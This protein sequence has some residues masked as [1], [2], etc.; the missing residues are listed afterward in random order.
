MAI[1]CL[2]SPSGITSRSL[3]M[4]E[5]YMMASFRKFFRT[6]AFL[7]LALL[8]LSSPLLAAIAPDVTSL[9][10][11]S[12]ALSTPVRLSADSGGVLYVTDPRAGGVVKYSSNGS[13]EMTIPAASGILGVAVAA[14]GNILVSQG[15]VVGVFSPAGVKL[16]EFGTFGKANGIAV[17][18]T[19]AIFVV[20]SL[21]NEVQIFNK[22]YTSAGRF[23]KVGTADGFFRQPTGIT[24]EKLADQ[25]AVTDTRNG[26]VQFFSTTGLFKKSI[27]SFGAG[28]LKFTSP[29][30]VSFEYTPDQSALKRIYIVDSYQS[31]IQV[32]DGA[33]LEFIRYIGGYG[34]ADGK[35]IT[36]SDILFDKSGRLVVANGTGKLSL[37]GVADPATGPYLQL[38]TVP[39]ATNQS[40]L[41]ISG[42][43]TG[44]T[45][46]VNGL[47]AT[48]SGTSWSVALPL[49]PGTNLI[50][51]TATDAAGLTTTRTASVL[52]IA[53][54]PNPVALTVQP[55]PAVVANSSLV[56]K[57]SVT[58]GSSVSVNGVS[59]TVSGTSWSANI[60]LHAGANTLAISAAKA[61][62]DTSTIDLTVTLDTTLPAIVTQLP[63]SGSV[64][65]SPLQTITGSASSAS[66]TTIILTVNGI[67][68]TVSVSD[69][70]FSLPIVLNPGQN[71]ISIAAVDSFGAM[72]QLPT[73]TVS[74]DPQA[75]HLTISTPAAAVSGTS[76]YHLEG[77]A[78]AGSTVT[79]NGS[80]IASVS[81]T[82]WSADV[83][84]VPG[85]NNFEV[86]AV[87]PSGSATS[88]MT[89]VSYSSGIPSLAIVSPIRDSAVASSTYNIS[90]TSSTG[91]VV[92]AL[93]N[94]VPA[95][96]TSS[97]NGAFT[98]VIP[99]MTQGTYT[100]VVSATNTNTG[101]T[102]TT[103]RSVIYDPVPPLLTVSSSV[104]P[105]K[106]SAPGGV[107]VASDKN[108]PVGTVTYSGGVA[109][110]D[111]TNVIYD[112]ATLN[113][114]ALSPAGLTSRS[115][116]FTGAAKP[117][118]ADALKA[119]RVAAR[120]DPTPAFAEML[121]GDVAPM[122]NFESRPDGK[123]SLDDVVVI[124][125]RILGIIP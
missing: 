23:G 81:G 31:T 68:Q 50:V 84:L 95:Q 6:T 3:V 97:S 115:G 113:I 85:V 55:L 90:G 67:T 24:Y 61:G 47:P 14:D 62:M 73:T 103:T 51:V 109:S 74:Y 93:I 96:V 58:A 87:T 78:P 46:S 25:I 1:K 86:T 52:A 34:V 108:G 117:T 49:V 54:S 53:S 123:I 100:V 107:L 43:T 32:I 65:S 5:P 22:D 16:R 99:N 45:V 10:S 121:T 89:S 106:V 19:G 9:S 28:P 125:N 80:V 18:G 110:L 36:P 69:G 39:Q 111:L 98:V 56:V 30:S 48:I 79:I 13:Y 59:A 88:A 119:L 7:M 57:G 63:V 94:S 91:V 35:L 120:I 2:I 42:T 104:L 26:R 60:T 64:F 41:L 92:T 71:A 21:N 83:Q 4:E 27:G 17:T 20:D 75:P 114:Q 40:S 70:V 29:Q 12:V 15:A 112:A 105:I 44:L 122:V 116:S 101:A 77:V 38:D 102:S 124:L 66:A 33:T 76:T 118:L 82:A 8:L 37:F 11:I 72:T